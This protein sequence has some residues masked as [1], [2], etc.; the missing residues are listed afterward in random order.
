M[1]H[2]NNADVGLPSKEDISNTIRAPEISVHWFSSVSTSKEA[3]S[4]TQSRH[5]KQDADCL[6][7]SEVHDLRVDASNLAKSSSGIS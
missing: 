7:V 4:V 6:E 1:Q 3:T 2:E 5:Q